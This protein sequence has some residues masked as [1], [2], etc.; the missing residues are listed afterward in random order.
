MSARRTLHVKEGRVGVVL[1]LGKAGWS[2]WNPAAQRELAT[3]P[4][5]VELVLQSAPKDAILERA[6]AIL[7]NGRYAPAHSNEY[8]GL[9]VAWVRPER[10]FR[11]K[12]NSAG[13]EE[14]EYYKED[15]WIC[16]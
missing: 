14:I 13:Y 6:N 15:E 4:I 10:P 1:S 2:T 9:T 11:V 3:D 16:A 12:I 8:S 7:P 5:L